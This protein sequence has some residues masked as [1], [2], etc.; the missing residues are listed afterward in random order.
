MSNMSDEI[1][2]NPIP[3]VVRGTGFFTPMDLAPGEM[4]MPTSSTPSAPTQ[5][6]NNPAPTPPANTP[7]PQEQS[8]TGSG[9]NGTNN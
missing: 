7:T 4:P 2:K 6:T 3:R 8:Q 9:T 1:N 5:P